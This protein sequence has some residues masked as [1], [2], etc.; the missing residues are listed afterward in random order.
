MHY[1]LANPALSEDFFYEEYFPESRS[2]K[3]FIRYKRFINSR[4]FRNI[5]EEFPTHDHHILPKS[6]C[7]GSW[8]EEKK[9]NELNLIPLSL[10]EHIVA[11]MFLWKAFG[12]KMTYVF[13]MMTNYYR[14]KFNSRLYE[15]LKIEAINQHK[16]F[17]KEYYSKEENR[18]QRGDFRRGKTLEEAFG[19]ERALIIRE[20]LSN[21]HYDCS[22]ENN[23]FFGKH[24]STRT[25]RRL[26]SL[27][28]GKTFE[29]IF[30]EEKAKEVKSTLSEKTQQRVK[31][32]EHIFQNLEKHPREGKILLEKEDKKKFVLFDEVPDYLNRG[33]SASPS[34][35]YFSKKRTDEEKREHYKEAASKRLKKEC[36]ICGR[37]IANPVYSRHY[38]SCE[39]KHS[40]SI[41]WDE[42]Y[43]K[44]YVIMN[45]GD[46][47]IHIK[48]MEVESLLREGWKLGNLR[49]KEIKRYDCPLCEKENLDP[50]GFSVHMTSR[51]KWTKE[52]CSL[53]REKKDNELYTDS[54]AK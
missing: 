15:M 17:L 20:K 6:L 7:P 26:A 30:G 44:K 29:E 32:G 46:T 48:P 39:R 14:T 50:G 40:V 23:S 42:I 16:E 1:N 21:N 28:E 38:I 3:D 45:N 8:T 36:P 27:R 53:Y 24:H 12:G 43:K 2:Q 51:H 33:W 54:F 22:G 52:E 49:R 11:H 13:N 9:D 34:S 25:K 18:L 31:R 19:E 5:S 41:D 47:I 35:T 4:K 10:R 37:M